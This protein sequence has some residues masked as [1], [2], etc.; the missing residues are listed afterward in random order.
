MVLWLQELGHEL[1]YKG[2]KGGKKGGKRERE[3]K[4]ARRE[5][6]WREI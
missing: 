6:K 1:L 3:K 4:G 5:R 2:G